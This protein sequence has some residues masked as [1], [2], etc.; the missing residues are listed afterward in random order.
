MEFVNDYIV[1]I[2]NLKINCY[3][4]KK[5][6]RKAGS[7]FLPVPKGDIFVDCRSAQITNSCQFA[8]VEVP[9]L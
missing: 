6:L 5:N 9:L 1:N 4:I 7:P 2:K 3:N 8:D